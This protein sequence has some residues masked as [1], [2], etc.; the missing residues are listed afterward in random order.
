MDHLSERLEDRAGV[1]QHTQ[2]PGLRSTRTT[3]GWFCHSCSES[4]VSE[5]SS[6][7][8]L[9]RLAPLIKDKGGGVMLVIGREYEV[10]NKDD[11]L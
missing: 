5:A 7:A 6:P 1:G 8:S 2:Q 4:T 9:L 3:A 11:W 10:D